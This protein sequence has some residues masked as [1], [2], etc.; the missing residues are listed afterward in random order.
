MERITTEIFPLLNVSYPEMFL[1][2]TWA[3]ITQACTFVKIHQII[4]LK[5]V[6]FI[7]RKDMPI[8]YKWFITCIK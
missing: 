1:I 6:H 5:P 4:Y 7:L 8:I 3:T 2:L